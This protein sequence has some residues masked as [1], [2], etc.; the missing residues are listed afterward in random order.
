M[1]K[2]NNL[3]G[4]VYCTLIC[5]ACYAISIIIFAFGVISEKDTNAL[6]ILLI[7]FT[8]FFAGALY[9]TYYVLF[10]SYQQWI[11]KDNDIIVTTL[12]YQNW[13]REN[14]ENNDESYF[15]EKYRDKIEGG[16]V[17]SVSVTPLYDVEIIMDN[18]IKI[19]LFVKN[20]YH[21]FDDENEQWVF[22]REDDHSHPFISVWSKSV[23]IATTW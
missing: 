21:H 23:D 5:L 6:V 11:I 20:G 9:F 2:F 4:S 7:M 16:I 19:E 15:V 3:L 14:D 18:G 1:K 8:S 22:F 13:D 12:D 17:I 10:C